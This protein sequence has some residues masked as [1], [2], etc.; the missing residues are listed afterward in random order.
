MAPWLTESDHPRFISLAVVLSNE[1][2]LWTGEPG[3]MNDH[4]KLIHFEFS[5]LLAFF[6]ALAY[7]VNVFATSGRPHA[8]SDPDPCSGF[9]HVEKPYGDPPPRARL[10]IGARRSYRLKETQKLWDQTSNLETEEVTQIAQGWYKSW[11]KFR[12][13][14]GILSQ[15]IA[16]SRAIW[17][18]PVWNSP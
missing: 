6:W 17:A 11:A 3:S 9:R 7:V 10:M 12:P 1:F 5:H 14:I 18:D 2:A 15:N 4:D 8:I 16:R 13:L